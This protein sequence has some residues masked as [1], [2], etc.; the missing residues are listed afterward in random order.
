MAQ[1]RLT[2]IMKKPAEQMAAYYNKTAVERG[3]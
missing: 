1:K 2:W 3:E